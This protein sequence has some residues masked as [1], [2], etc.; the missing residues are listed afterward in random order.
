MGPFTRN[1]KSKARPLLAPGGRKYESDPF[2]SDGKTFTITEE[3]RKTVGILSEDLESYMDAKYATVLGLDEHETVLAWG[4]VWMGI[5]GHDKRFEGTAVITPQTIMAWWQPR[6]R[7]L[8][9]TFQASHTAFEA[10]EYLGPTA[11]HFRWT[12]GVCGNDSGK[13]I[14]SGPV[15]FIASR[16]SDKDGHANRRTLEVY[17]TFASFLPTQG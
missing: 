15:W 2:D 9:H 17:Y 1:K 6:K 8:I 13:F 16:F 11:A 3:R 10:Y 7:G 4:P 5:R 12:T 14:A